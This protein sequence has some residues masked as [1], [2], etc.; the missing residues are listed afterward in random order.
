M[1][2]ERSSCCQ[3]MVT[4]EACVCSEAGHYLIAYV[5]MG[6]YALEAEPS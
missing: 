2:C 5:S 4:Q 3:L 6:L 1:V